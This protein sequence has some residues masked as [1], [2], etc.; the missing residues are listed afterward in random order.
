MKQKAETPAPV[1]APETPKLEPSEV[2]AGLKGKK[3]K[4]FFDRLKGAAPS[5][6]S[7]AGTMGR[8]FNNNNANKKL[9]NE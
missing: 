7:F 9:L 5:I 1:P 4:N 6:L 3:G 2:D 8:F